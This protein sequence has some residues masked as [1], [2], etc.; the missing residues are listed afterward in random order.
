MDHKEDGKIKIIEDLTT[1][2]KSTRSLLESSSNFTNINLKNPPSKVITPENFLRPITQVY[3]DDTDNLQTWQP[4]IEILDPSDIRKFQKLE[5]RKNRLILF[6]N[7][8]LSIIFRYVR[9][10]R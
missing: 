10:I 1:L 8:L 9:R 2:K 4:H 5:E 3:I 7:P 6:K